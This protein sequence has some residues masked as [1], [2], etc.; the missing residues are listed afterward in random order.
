MKAFVMKV[1]MILI[2]WCLLLAICWPLAVLMVALFPLV[3]MICLPFRIAYTVV[4]AFLAFLKTL[5]F[6]PARILGYRG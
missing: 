5:L 3:W 1:L 6:L 2:L 4:T